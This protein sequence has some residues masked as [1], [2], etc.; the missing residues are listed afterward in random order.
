M[1]AILIIDDET[2]KRAVLRDILEPLGHTVSEAGDAEAGL[3]LVHQQAFDLIFVDLVL[4]GMSGYKFLLALQQVPNRTLPPVILNSSL[5]P[6]EEL[7]SFGQL[8]GIPHVLAMPHPPRLKTIVGLV[9]HALESATHAPALMTQPS[10]HTKEL[11]EKLELEIGQL[12]ELQKLRE[13]ESP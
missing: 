9:Q 5:Y 7:I 12:R 3:L 2:L 1:S 10:A 13:Q 11:I 8:L 4:P 6:E